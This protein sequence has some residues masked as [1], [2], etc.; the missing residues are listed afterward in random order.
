MRQKIKGGGCSK[1]T[2]RCGSISPFYASKSG[3]V[4]VIGNIGGYENL[5]LF[6]IA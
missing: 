5:M 1:T 4:P 3:L 2:G 6:A